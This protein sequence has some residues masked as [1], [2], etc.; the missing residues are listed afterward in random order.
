MYVLEAPLRSYHSCG[1]KASSKGFICSEKIAGR[2]QSHPE[3]AAGP[4][5]IAGCMCLRPLC[6]HTIL[7]DVRH[8][9][10]ASSVRYLSGFLLK[11]CAHLL[12]VPGRIPPV[13][14]A[15]AWTAEE[16]RA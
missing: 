4:F 7:A 13:G 12:A 9:A 15:P 10:R 11:E 2:R 16:K 3:A 1:C 8:R 6:G 5:A 14:P